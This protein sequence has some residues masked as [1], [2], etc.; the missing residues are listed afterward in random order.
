MFRAMRK[1]QITLSFLIIFLLVEIKAFAAEPPAPSSMNSVLAI[2]M[3]AFAFLLLICIGI[4]ANVLLFTARKQL[5]KERSKKAAPVITATILLL[6]FNKAGAQTAGTASVKQ[7]VT[8]TVGGMSEFA[9][10]TLMSVIFLELLVIVVMLLQ[11]KFL[12]RDET[13]ASV[14]EAR[15]PVLKNLSVKWWNKLNSF[16]PVEQE[17]DIDLGHDYDGI[18][19]LDNRLPPWWLYG[20]YITIIAGVI[21]L[22]RYQVSH[23]GLSNVQE[24]EASVI[25]ADQDIKAY[26]ELKG[27]SVDENTV[28]LL[29]DQGDLEAGKTIFT[30]TCATCHKANGAGDVGPNLTDEY[31]LH[32]G[33]LKSVFKTIRYGAG[34]MPQWQNNFSNKQIAQVASYVKSLGGTKPPGAKAPQGELYKEAI[35]DTTKKEPKIIAN[36]SH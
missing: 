30:S 7:T 14:R 4:L 1:I 29:T 16:R 9:F 20:F 27:E 25:K 35:A 5:E 26:L 15:I 34:A 12:L 11:I 18:R 32:G 24:Y 10:Y 13:L 22:Y 17:A 28:T 19:E 21:Y 33:S 3:V 8:E 31:W 23:T 6:L 2:F 36:L